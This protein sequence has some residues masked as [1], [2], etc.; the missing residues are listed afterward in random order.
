M[1]D[2]ILQAESTTL[3]LNGHAFTDLA[4][5]DAIMLSTVNDATSRANSNNGV[6]IAARGDS[7]VVDLTVKVQRYSSDDALLNEWRNGGKVV[8]INGSLKESFNRDDADFLESWSLEA[9]SF[10]TKGDQVKNNQDVD[11]VEEYTMQ[12]RRGIRSL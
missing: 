7:N 4:E 3:I 11:A 10:T 2:I 12:F 6:T 9:G 1:S 5:A 8:V